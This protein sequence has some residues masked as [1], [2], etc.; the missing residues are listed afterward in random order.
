[1]TKHRLFSSAAIAAKMRSYRPRRRKA[2]KPTGGPRPICRICVEK[3]A[4][5]NL[6]KCCCG[7]AR[8]IGLL[9]PLPR[10][11][12]PRSLSYS[13]DPVFRI[14]ADLQRPRPAIP[15]VIDGVEFLIVWNGA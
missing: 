12:D 1:M 2:L 9:P 3:L 5:P 10:A 7:C 4:R 14:A 11:T 6:D 15:R 8:A 13:P